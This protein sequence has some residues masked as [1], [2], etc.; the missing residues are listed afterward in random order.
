MH[1]SHSLLQSN[2]RDASVPR[3]F[4]LRSLRAPRLNRD[5]MQS[6][7]VAVPLL[8]LLQQRRGRSAVEIDARDRRLGA[9]ENDVLGFLDV[10]LSAAQA[11]E[12]VGQ[13]PR[14]IA[15]ADNKKVRGR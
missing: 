1:D 7:D 3:L 12:D 2:R 10:D 9:F 15:V 5:E 4:S 8:N 14:T 11:I 6:E 13:H